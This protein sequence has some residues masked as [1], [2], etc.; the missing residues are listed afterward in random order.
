MY[1]AGL[2]H[3]LRQWT[4]YTYGAPVVVWATSETDALSQVRG[5]RSASLLQGAR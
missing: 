2:A 1:H 4:V 3:G 5:S